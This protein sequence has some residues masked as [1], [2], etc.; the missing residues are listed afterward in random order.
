MAKVGTLGRD[1]PSVGVRGPKRVSRTV[2]PQPRERSNPGAGPGILIEGFHPLTERILA[3]LPGPRVAWMALWALLPWLEHAT[4][5][6]LQAAGVLASTHN[7]SGGAPARAAFS[8][9]ILVSVWGSGKITREIEALRPKLSRIVRHSGKD[10]AALFRGIGSTA[11]PLLL[12]A[13]A[14]TIFVTQTLLE[15]GWVESIVRASAWLVIGPAIWTLVWVYLSLQVGLDRLGRRHL[16]LDPDSEG[17]DLGLRPVGRLAFSAFWILIAG[18]APLAILNTG[19]LV[20]LTMTLVVLG[21][22][23]A[24]FFLSLRRLNRRMVATKQR[25]LAWARG[26]YQDALRPVRSQGTLEAVQN[27]A[28]L[29][30]AAEALEQRAERIQEWPF[31]EAT[32]ARVVAIAS[33][34]TA[35]TLA[36]LI[37]A[38][39]GI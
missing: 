38:P 10:P 18:A 15:A 28:G 37:L 20:A 24:A 16:E 19:D 1:R 21:V 33:F 8:F 6:S 25:Q 36:R 12:N 17:R 26:L 27:Q 29:L 22:G 13:A 11:A 39:F 31:D 3:R 9:A 34:V 2:A 4:F 30:S 35:G 32:F 23:V 7:P 5:L 14:I